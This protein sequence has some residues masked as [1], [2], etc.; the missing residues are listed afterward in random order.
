MSKRVSRIWIIRELIKK[1]YKSVRPT[2]I[3]I[4]ELIYKYDLNR[5]TPDGKRRNKEVLAKAVAKACKSLR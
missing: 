3:Q 2:A 5:H 1:H 4:N